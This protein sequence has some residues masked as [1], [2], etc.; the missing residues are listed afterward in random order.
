VTASMAAGTFTPTSWMTQS[1]SDLTTAR[2]LHDQE[3]YDWASY[4]AAQAAEKAV[5]AMLIAW[6]ADLAHADR[7]K[8]WRIHQLTELLHIFRKWPKSQTLADALT[9]LPAHDEGAR[10]P[11]RANDMPP[12]K[13]YKKTTS[14]QNIEWAAAVV[15]FSKHLVPEI[16]RA[17]KTLETAAQSLVP[18]SEPRSLDDG[19]A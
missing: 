18:P 11:N 6:G 16:E 17:V 14:A 5:K 8:P 1:E 2:L 4:A 9:N 15:D 3:K 13:S 10:Y 19:S 12:C 7:G